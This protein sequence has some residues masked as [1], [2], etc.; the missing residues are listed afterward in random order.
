M[1]QFIIVIKYRM[2]LIFMK[3]L[4]ILS[5]LLSMAA[6]GTGIKGISQKGDYCTFKTAPEAAEIP[7]IISDAE[8]VIEGLD[9]DIPDSDDDI[10]YQSYEGEKLDV[11]MMFF[12]L[13]KKA[14]LSKIRRIEFEDGIKIVGSGHTGRLDLGE[15]TKFN[16][17]NNTLRIIEN[18]NENYED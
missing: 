1:L 15:V 18:N 2:E 13:S 8:C 3:K 7:Y 14:N 16:I 6:F 11:P 4:V 17:S 9:Y 5:F 12:D 10:H